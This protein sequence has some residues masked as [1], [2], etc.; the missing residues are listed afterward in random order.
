MENG[1]R[2]NKTSYVKER[3]IGR[4]CWSRSNVAAVDAKM[5]EGASYA[6][7]LMPKPPSLIGN[8]T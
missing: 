7:H 6:K 5:A 8:I 2:S 1:N 3:G 4:M